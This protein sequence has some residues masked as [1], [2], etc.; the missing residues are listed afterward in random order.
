MRQSQDRRSILHLVTDV[1]DE[2]TQLFQTEIRLVRAEFNQKISNVA[3][4]ATLLVMGAVAGIAAL[5]LLLQ[6]VVA[7]LAVA[8]LP[9]QWGL[10]LVGLVVGVIGIVVVMRG[11]GILRGTTLVPQKTLDQL[12]ADF[13]TVK[14][15]LT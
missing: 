8:G 7:W 1:I 12:G 6:A 4:A 5:F 13:T 15:H 14:E 11:I 2:M 9:E 3:T 10:L